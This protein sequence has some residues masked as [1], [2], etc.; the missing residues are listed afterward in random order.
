MAIVHVGE[1]NFEKEVLKSEIPVMVDFWAP[2]CGPCR[3]L[4]PVIDEIAEEVIGT[5]ICKCD[6]DKAM[7]IAKKYR[8]MSIPTLILFKNG[9]NVKSLIGVR[10][11]SEILEM[12]NS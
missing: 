12:I 3:S 10:T 11:K 5:K 4:A 1:D 2:W 9:E 7:N 6:T 8:I